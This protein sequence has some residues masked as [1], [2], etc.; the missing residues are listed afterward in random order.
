MQVQ[1]MCVFPQ[2]SFFSFFFV[3]SLFF[4]ICSKQLSLADWHVPWTNWPK[5]TKPVTVLIKQLYCCVPGQLV[6]NS[7]KPA[8]IKPWNLISLILYA[9]TQSD[10]MKT[11]QKMKNYY[12]SSYWNHREGR[13][14]CRTDNCASILRL[15]ASPLTTIWELEQQERHCTVVTKRE[16]SQKAL[17]LPS[18]LSSYFHP[19]SWSVGHDQKNKVADTSGWN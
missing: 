14:F 17:C 11:M 3:F 19:W 18:T 2:F 6:W 5:W 4:V 9:K 13:T 15:W 12:K 7:P 16:L 8:F 1:D 10:F